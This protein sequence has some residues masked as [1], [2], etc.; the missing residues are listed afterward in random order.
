MATQGPGR[1]VP[2]SM[3]SAQ[4]YR[5]C[6]VTKGH[7]HF[8]NHRRLCPFATTWWAGSERSAYSRR[9]DG[10]WQLSR[11]RVSDPNRVMAA[12]AWHIRQGV[13]RGHG[14]IERRAHVRRSR[15][16]YCR[17]AAWHLPGSDRPGGHVANERVIPN[18]LGAARFIEAA[19]ATTVNWISNLI[20]QPGVLNSGQRKSDSADVAETLG[21]Q[22]RRAA[23]QPHH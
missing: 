9:C 14:R 1:T 6:S 7:P 20:R 22:H 11:R 17:N 5:A 4:P 3:R 19:M 2:A 10:G 23:T 16:V 12:F 15:R 13:R 21:E 8:P 18:G